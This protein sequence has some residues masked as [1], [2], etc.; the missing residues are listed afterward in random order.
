[1]VLDSLVRHQEGR[2]RAAH[3]HRFELPLV[4]PVELQPQ[5]VPMGP[6]ALGLLL[7]DG[8]LTTSTT[9]S[10]TTADPELAVALEAALDGIEL[11]RKSQVDDVLRHV[12]GPRGG[13]IV[14]NP[15]T[16]VLRDLGLPLLS[17]IRADRQELPLP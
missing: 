1:M 16:V 9:P 6:Y 7:G 13:V 3:A 17:V 14:A 8:C 5:P 4:K 12:A 10:F 15:V 2:L 11:R